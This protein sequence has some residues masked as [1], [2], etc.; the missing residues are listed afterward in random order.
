MREIGQCKYFVK[1]EKQVT[2]IQVV[3]VSAH[4]ALE[5]AESAL[6]SAKSSAAVN[7]RVGLIEIVEAD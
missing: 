7:E 3:E 4:T 5:A 1:L 6:E 2:S